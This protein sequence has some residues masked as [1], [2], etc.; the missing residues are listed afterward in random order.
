[1]FVCAQ[2]GFAGGT[3]RIGIKNPP[4]KPIPYKSRPKVLPDPTKPINNSINNNIGTKQKPFNAHV[5]FSCKRRSL[6]AKKI[7]GLRE[8]GKTELEQLTTA[9]DDA[10]KM[11]IQEVYQLHGSAAEIESEI[12]LDCMR[13]K[14]L[15]LPN[16]NTGDT[17]IASSVVKNP[18]KC[19]TI[20]TSLDDLDRRRIDGPG[21]EKFLDDLQQQ[22][23]T[24][25]REMK[26]AGCFSNPS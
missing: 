8:I 1:M 14:K 20:K 3:G 9:K 17:K 21:S 16:S 6:D 23:Y 4:P 18:S 2:T 13:Q 12:A 22:Q 10:A 19:G 11:L 7:I 25:M 15:A 26:A 24:L 5:D